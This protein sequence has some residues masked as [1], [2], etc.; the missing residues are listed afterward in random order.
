MPY[1]IAHSVAW[2][3]DPLVF[4]S[5]EGADEVIAWFG[6]VPSFHDASIKRMEFANSDGILEIAA[7]RM[8]DKVD[9]KGFFV[10]DRHAVVTLH[11]TDVSG[12][13]LDCHSNPTVLEVGIRRL[14]SE[15]LPISN[16]AASVGDFEIAFDDVFG[17]AG[18]LYAREV[19]M[20]CSPQSVDG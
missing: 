17:G 1:S 16:T 2:D 8:T 9:D 4:Q 6:Y 5:L 15:H 18:S 12:I 13:L 3:F 20:T 7:F 10:L 19:R 14:A 11:L